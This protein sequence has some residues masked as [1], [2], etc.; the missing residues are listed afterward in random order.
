MED[1]L[2][3]L[4]DVETVKNKAFVENSITTDAS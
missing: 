4:Q 2:P 1:I 3:N